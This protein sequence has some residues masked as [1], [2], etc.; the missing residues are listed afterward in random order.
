MGEIEQS[1]FKVK[2]YS[3]QIKFK[4]PRLSFQ[5]SIKKNK[6]YLIRSYIPLKIKYKNKEIFQCG[7]NVQNIETQK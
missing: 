3:Q 5:E 7:K 6:T 4:K 1:N 2:L